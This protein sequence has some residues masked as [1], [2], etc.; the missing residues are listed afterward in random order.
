MFCLLVVIKADLKRHK[1]ELERSSKTVSSA[2]LNESDI[3]AVN[4][5]NISASYVNKSY[6]V[7]EKVSCKN[8]NVTHNV[9]KFK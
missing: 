5:N 6:E 3:T 1:A 7:D 9:V 8:D 4:N 2:T